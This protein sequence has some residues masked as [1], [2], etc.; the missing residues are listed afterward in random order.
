MFHAYKYKHGDQRPMTSP[1]WSAGS[2]KGHSSGKG[3]AQLKKGDY[4]KTNP[5]SSARW[6]ETEKGRRLSED[7][8]QRT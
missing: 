6:E 1:S 3:H 7:E 8:G 2:A 4:E 5:N